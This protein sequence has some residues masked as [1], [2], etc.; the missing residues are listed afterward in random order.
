M[1]PLLSPNNNVQEP[2]GGG[3]SAMEDNIDK[4]K[5]NQPP[6]WDIL[7]FECGLLSFILLFPISTLHRIHLEY[8]G[9]LTTIIDPATL[10]N[11]TLSLWSIT[12]PIIST[13]N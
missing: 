10:E 8:E 11:R 6:I 4:K 1:A 7:Q 2:L 5:R 3:N 9:L 12:S 13:N